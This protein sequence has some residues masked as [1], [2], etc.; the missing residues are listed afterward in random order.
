M[1]IAW[2]AS[3][4]VAL[5]AASMPSPSSPPPPPPSPLS[6]VSVTCAAAYGMMLRSSTQ[7]A[8]WI[9]SSFAAVVPRDCFSW[10]KSVCAGPRPTHL[11]RN[12]RRVVTR[13]FF[14]K[15]SPM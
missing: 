7:H 5:L 6:Q 14:K 15:E 11:N 4:S 9:G 13:H 1:S 3:P 12:V 2:I 8:S 10:R